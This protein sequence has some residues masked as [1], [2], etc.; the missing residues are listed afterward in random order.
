MCGISAVIV[1]SLPT[2]Y[3]DLL[4][5]SDIRGQDGTGVT[6]LRDAHFMTHRWNCRAKDIKDFPELKEG[7]LVIG[8]NRLAIFGL[9]HKNDQ[10]LL[11]DRFALVHNGNLLDFEKMFKEYGLRRELQVDS[12]LILR[13]IEKVSSSLQVPLSAEQLYRDAVMGAVKGDMACLLLDT[14]RI[15]ITCFV[16][17]KPLHVKTVGGNTYLFSTER[18]GKKVFP[19]EY[20]DTITASSTFI[21]ENGRIYTWI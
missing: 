19:S 5:V 16:R 10:P 2:L 13:L 3:W 6:I 17:N 7:D 20:T 8:Q 4:K 15:G 11:T 1:R 14:R 12:E 21:L 18:I 9:D